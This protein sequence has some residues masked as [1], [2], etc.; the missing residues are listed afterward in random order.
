[1][2]HKKWGV[3]GDNTKVTTNEA[4]QLWLVLQPQK[5]TT[6]SS[7]WQLSPSVYCWSLKRVLTH[8]FQKVRPLVSNTVSTALLNTVFL[9]DSHWAL[10]D[11][12]I[13]YSQF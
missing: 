4:L 11:D 3:L 2:K 9:P 5:D 8:S 1:M 12:V 6:L 10:A 13:N 7:A